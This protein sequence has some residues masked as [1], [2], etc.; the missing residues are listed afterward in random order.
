MFNSDP[1]ASLLDP[2]TPMPLKAMEAAGSFGESSRLDCGRY[3]G[4]V[5]LLR[6]VKYVRYDLWL[7]DTDGYTGYIG[8]C[9]QLNQV[10]SG[11][12]QYGYGCPC[13]CTNRTDVMVNLVNSVQDPMHGSGCA[14]SMSQGVPDVSFGMQGARYSDEVVA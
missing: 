4:W 8:V 10:I 9:D 3:I 14:V 6:D 11:E 12:V 13:G 5:A 1:A 2:E 7:F